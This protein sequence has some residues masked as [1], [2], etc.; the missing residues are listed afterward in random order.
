MFAR[1]GMHLVLTGA[2]LV[3]AIGACSSIPGAGSDPASRQEATSTTEEAVMMPQAPIAFDPGP[4][5][6]A[7]GAGA[8][9]TPQPIDSH[10][11]AIV[12]L[13]TFM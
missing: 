10:P 2:A 6:G 4:R 13:A 7:A 5:P 11:T 1:S 3:G 9:A 8:P 12:L